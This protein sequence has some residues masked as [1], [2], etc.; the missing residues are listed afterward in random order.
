MSRE[1]TWSPGALRVFSLLKIVIISL[2]ENTIFFS[3]GGS[4]SCIDLGF[5]C[6]FDFI[7]QAWWEEVL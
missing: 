6:G 2:G 4:G 1:S 5:V 3:I 7:V